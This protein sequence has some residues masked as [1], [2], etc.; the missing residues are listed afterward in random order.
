MSLYRQKILDE[1]SATNLLQERAH[2][3]FAPEHR[4]CPRC[5]HRLLVRKTRAREVVVLDT[6]PFTAEET[7]SYCLRCP[8]SP[9]YRSEE[10]SRLVAPGARFGYDVM[11]HVGRATFQRYRTAEEIV[12]ELGP[13][14]VPISPSEVRV[15]ARRFVLYLAEAH[16]ESQE[17]LKALLKKQGGYILHLDSTCDGASSHLFSALDGLSD[18]VLLSVKIDSEKADE[19]VPI[20]KKL[21]AIYGEPLAIMSDMSRA[22]CAAVKQVFKKLRHYIC[23][24]HFLRD[25]GKD[26][27]EPDYKKI[28]E[29]LRA[30]GICALLRRRARELRA[31]MST[32]S[33]AVESLIKNLAQGSLPAAGSQA[34]SAPLAYSMIEWTLAGKQ[35]GNG[36]GFPFD[37]PLVHFYERLKIL[38]QALALFERAPHAQ[39]DAKSSLAAKLTSDLKSVLDDQDL[40]AIVAAIHQKRE[41]FDQLRKAMRIAQPDGKEGLN[42]DGE[43]IHMLTIEKNVTAFH[44]QLR[45]RLDFTDDGPY[46]NMAAQIKKYWKQLFADPIR[47]HTPAGSTIIYPNRTNNSLERLFRALNRDHRRQTGENSMRRRL[48]AMLG[49]TP[50]VKNLENPIYMEILLDGSPTLEE[51]FA[52]IDVKLIRNQMKKARQEAGRTLPGLRKIF[53]LPTWPLDVA[54]LWIQAK[55][56]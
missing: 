11:V 48:D 12:A 18:L 42:D 16:G 49:H 54:N 28:R 30:H 17:A 26:L 29:L 47:V 8:E 46:G 19:I 7:Q 43:D 53:S 14:N 6:G 36:Y 38:S 51:R 4:E 40:Q 31:Q 20:L 55:T 56:G 33:E 25:I 37:L 39:D 3:R 44:E 23:H 24:F 5:N 34:F 32:E 15:Q 22:I 13:R 35:Q 52:R 21:K 41:V 45:L 50:L 2:L 1:M 9:V 27:L 10:L